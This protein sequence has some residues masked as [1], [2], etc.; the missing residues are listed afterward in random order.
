MIA[1][2]IAYGLIP[3]YS[4]G[5]GGN[6]AQ[7]NPL[8]ACSANTPGQACC[9]KASNMGWRYT[10]LCLGAI[11][12]FIFVLRF[13]LFNFQESPKFLLY[14][15]KDEKAVK[16]LQHIAKFNGR[17]CGVTL[18]NF[19]ALDREETDVTGRNTTTPIMFVP[20]VP[21][22]D[23]WKQRIKIEFVRYKMLF[24]NAQIARLTILV[25]ITYVSLFPIFL[26][27]CSRYFWTQI[28]KGN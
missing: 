11:C 13:V 23:T 5:D 2:G 28:S 10:C 7:G 15:N 22:K 21:F 26:I 24:G 8:P 16:A 9:T 19:K 27:I 3:R 1:S 14:R 4:C 12:L 6:D 25:W 20:D 17:D 18:D